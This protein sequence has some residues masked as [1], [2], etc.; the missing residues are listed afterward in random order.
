MGSVRINHNGAGKVVM[1]G[2]LAADSECRLGLKGTVGLQGV[3]VF[4]ARI[5]R[6]KTGEYKFFLRV[7]V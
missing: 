3:L 7:R 1:A 2:G 4:W 6:Q 5:W